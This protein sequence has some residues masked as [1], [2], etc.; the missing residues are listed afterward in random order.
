MYLHFLLLIMQPKTII[1]NKQAIQQRIVRMAFAIVE[2]NYNTQHIILAGIAPNGV[3]I[4]KQL[5]FQIETI[6]NIKTELITINI[7][8]KEPHQ[9]TIPAFD[10][11]NKTIIIIDDVSM[12][13]K[14]ICFSL[15]PFL[16]YYPYKIQTLVLVER[17]LKN[18][19]IHSDYVGLHVSTTEKN[20]IIVEQENDECTVAYLQ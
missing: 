13:G 11:N 20:L 16:K 2:Q 7:N 6:S 1:L 3:G 5:A 9:V 8:K 18:Y 14:T 15:V 4:S 17:Q 12:T 10:Y 19:P